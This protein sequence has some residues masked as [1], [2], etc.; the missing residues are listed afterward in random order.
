MSQTYPSVVEAHSYRLQTMGIDLKAHISNVFAHWGST[1]R[2]FKF[3]CKDWRGFMKAIAFHPCFGA[4]TGLGQR[5]Q[6]GA[7]FREVGK[8][9]GLHLIFFKNR[10]VTELKTRAD[11]VNI[12]LDTVSVAT[13]RDADGAAIYEYSTVLQHVITDLKH[14]PFIVPDKKRG[15]MVGFRF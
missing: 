6:L 13:A 8:E 11:Y 1:P 14:L 7:S 9:D 10:M 2:G 4:D 3:T 5:F 15:P 12:H